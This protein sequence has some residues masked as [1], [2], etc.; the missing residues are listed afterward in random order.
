MTFRSFSGHRLDP[1]RSARHTGLVQHFFTSARIR[2]IVLLTSS[3]VLLVLVGQGRQRQ[4]YWSDCQI[5]PQGTDDSTWY[6][7]PDVSFGF[8]S[9]WTS[10]TCKQQGYAV[11]LL[12]GNPLWWSHGLP[13]GRTSITFTSQLLNDQTL[14][15]TLSVWAKQKIDGQQAFDTVRLGTTDG[16]VRTQISPDHVFTQ[17]IVI[18][19]GRRRFIF[20]MIFQATSDTQLKSNNLSLKPSTSPLTKLIST[21]S[22]Q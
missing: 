22:F 6:Q 10:A 3:I 17:D 1:S 7:G 19:H 11:K 4:R 2:F 14:P 21:V 12:D 8:P 16:L 13:V 5:R 20:T 9:K 18:D 15:K